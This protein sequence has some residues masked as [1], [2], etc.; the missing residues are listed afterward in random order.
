MLFNSL[1]FVFFFFSVTVAYFAIPH[2]LRWILLLGA[3][4]YFYACWNVGYLTLILSSTTVT[5]LTGLKM[6][7]GVSSYRKKACLVISLAVNLGLIMV[8]KY[9]NFFNESFRCLFAEMGLEYRI[10]N[11]DVLLPVGISF[12]TFQALSYSIDVYKGQRAPERHPGIF[13]LYIAFFPQLVAGP[14]ERSLRLLP[15]FH[16]KL[17]FDYDRITDGFSLVEFIY[18]QF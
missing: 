10:P 12:Y 8:F 3:S 1:Q 18:F 13:A 9:Y 7:T 17:Y 16:K 15:Q 6:G 14:I 2:R 5:Y 11:L 4:Y